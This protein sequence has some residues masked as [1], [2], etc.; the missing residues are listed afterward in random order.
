MAERLYSPWSV[1]LDA[2]LCVECDQRVKAKCRKCAIC[3]ITRK[4]P[5]YTQLL[6]YCPKVSKILEE[7]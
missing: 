7:K 4:T 3:M 5:K 1:K 6:G 2:T